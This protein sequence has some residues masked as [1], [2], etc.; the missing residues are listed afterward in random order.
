MG[1][2][3]LILMYSGA[4]LANGQNVLQAWSYEDYME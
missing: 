3:D 4:K 1:A 2:V